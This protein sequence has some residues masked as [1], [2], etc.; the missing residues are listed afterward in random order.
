MTPLLALLALQGTASFEDASQSFRLTRFPAN[1]FVINYATNRIAFDAKG[2]GL[3]IVRRSAG[4]TIQASLLKGEATQ[5]AEN[6]KEYEP[7]EIEATGNVVV[8]LDS[9]AEDEWKKETGK[10]ITKRP[11]DNSQS[12]IRTE[13]LLYRRTPE[14]IRITLP[15]A[16]T[17]TETRAGTA[18]ES[19]QGS[20]EKLPLQYRQSTHIQGSSGVFNLI[21]IL[22]SNEYD[23]RSG[24]VQGRVTLKSERNEVFVASKA[25]RTASLTAE[26]DKLDL[27]RDESSGR[28]VVEGN[29]FIRGRG[30]A[31]LD[32]DAQRA[33]VDL[34]ANG[35]PTVIR[36]SGTPVTTTVTVP[37]TTIEQSQKTKTKTP[38]ERP[39]SKPGGTMSQHQGASR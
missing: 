10:A 24:V 17:I 27:K 15:T 28:A 29:V 16:F 32:L 8:T 26:A 37:Q 3:L 39:K 34:D 19:K 35:K 2:D 21:R 31:S 6:P 18:L 14:G 9:K 20:K 11:Y 38:G 22:T 12:V 30:P 5:S 4:L 33:E 7:D 1:G 25:V 13:K 23:I 36:S